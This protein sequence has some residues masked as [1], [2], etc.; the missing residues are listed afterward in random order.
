MSRP[1]PPSGHLPPDTA[2]LHGEKLDLVALASAVTDRFF[3]EFPGDYE[4]Y[5]DV[6][7]QWCRHD[8][9]WIFLWAA[10]DLSGATDLIEQV[11]WLARVLAARD[12][13]L[14]RLVRSLEIAADVAVASLPSH[15]SELSRSLRSA[16]AAIAIG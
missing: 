15:G 12:Y 7:V 3:T 5:G 1:A 14:D 2:T 9:Q 6:G 13:P 11:R 4:R 10:Y 8:N 16:A